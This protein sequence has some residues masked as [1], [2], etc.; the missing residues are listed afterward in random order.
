MSLACRCNT[1]LWW[2]PT[3]NSPTW[4]NNSSSAADNVI[5]R[6]GAQ[7]IECSF[8]CMVRCAVLLKSNVAN[9]LL[10]SFCERKFFQHGPITASPCSFSKKNGPIMPLDQNP[11]QT[12][13]RFGYVSQYFPA[14]CKRLHNR[15]RSAEE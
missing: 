2:H 5:F 12:V 13:T 4:P 15:I 9:I 6:N 14:L 10:F 3:N 7:N 11:H 1:Y 8:G